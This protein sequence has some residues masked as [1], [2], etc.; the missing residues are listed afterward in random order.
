MFP[1]DTH[2]IFDV[3]KRVYTWTKHPAVWMMPTFS[4]T[5][6]TVMTQGEVM[7][8]LGIPCLSWFGGSTTL[9]ANTFGTNLWRR[10]ISVNNNKQTVY[11]WNTLK[12]YRYLAKRSVCNTQILFL[13]GLV[14]WLGPR[15]SGWKLFRHLSH[16]NSSWVKKKRT[17]GSASDLIQIYTVEKTVKSCRVQLKH[18]YL[19]AQMYSLGSTYQLVC[20][21]IIVQQ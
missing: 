19:L 20:L 17:N 5:F 21:S 11:W 4:K 9:T 13:V 12:K 18:L 7:W 3:A 1:R 2:Y 8:P 6:G 16:S 15:H 14:G 10:L